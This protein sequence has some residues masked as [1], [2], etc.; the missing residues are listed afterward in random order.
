MFDMANGNTMHK[1]LLAT[2]G[3]VMYPMLKSLVGAKR[4]FYLDVTQKCELPS[5]GAVVYAFNHQ[6]RQDTATILEAIGHYTNPLVAIDAT[7]RLGDR[8][9]LEL[10]DVTW[11]MR[12]DSNLSRERRSLAKKGK[13]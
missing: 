4:N 13:K 11:T 9:Q 1:K 7:P 6:T 12:G 3:R 10:I 8:L 2:T 5:D